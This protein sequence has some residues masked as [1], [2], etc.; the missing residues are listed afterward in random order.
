MILALN[1]T[2][3]I[4]L[5]VALS[6]FNPLP[7]DKIFRLVQIETK[8]RQQFKCIQNEKE[9]ALWDRKHFEKRRN[10][11]LQAISPFLTIFSTAIYL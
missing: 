10:C 9:N 6:L 3:L 4:H 8:C 11:L 1:E 2:G 7:V 5:R